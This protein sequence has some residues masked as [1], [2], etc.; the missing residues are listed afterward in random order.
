MEAD[1][2]INWI[3]SRLAYSLKH[4]S[5]DFTSQISSTNN[6][7]LLTSFLIRSSRRAL[8]ISS[9]SS[10]DVSLSFSPAPNTVIISQ[11]YIKYPHIN[12]VQSNHVSESLISADVTLSICIQD[13][14]WLLLNLFI[15]RVLDSDN[16]KVVL[17][18]KNVFDLSRSFRSRIAGDFSL[19]YIIVP[20][21]FLGSI[22][23][24]S[25][26]FEDI[27]S[28]WLTR[29][30]KVIVSP[31]EN[32]LFCSTDSCN[33]SVGEIISL[34]QKVKKYKK[35]HS[36]LKSERFVFVYN[37]LKLSKSWIVKKIDD[38]FNSIQQVLYESEDLL[39]YLLPLEKWVF[40]CLDAAPDSRRDYIQPICRLVYLIWDQCQFYQVQ[41]NF[42]HLLSSIILVIIEVVKEHLPDDLFSVPNRSIV[43]I[44][45]AL[46]L[47]YTFQGCYTDARTRADH[48]LDKIRKENQFEFDSLPE[49]LRAS[50]EFDKI[51]KSLPCKWPAR[52]DHIYQT[53][54]KTVNRLK[55]LLEIAKT[56]Y[57]FEDIRVIIE[58]GNNFSGTFNEYLEDI[59]SKFLSS[60]KPLLKIESNLFDVGD[61]DKFEGIFFAFRNETKTLEYRITNILKTYLSSNCDLLNLKK[62]QLFGRFVNRPI[63]RTSLMDFFVE[64]I[65]N[66]GEHIKD[67]ESFVSNCDKFRGFHHF[68]PTPI[69]KFLYLRALV[70]RLD[71]PY[72]L[73]IRISP[74]LFDLSASAVVSN[75]YLTV[76]SKLEQ[77]LDGFHFIDPELS[78]DFSHLLHKPVLITSGKSHTPIPSLQSNVVH[79]VYVAEYITKLGFPPT[80]I[81]PSLRILLEQYSN[82]E[83]HPQ[84]SKL[85]YT[86]HRFNRIWNN[87]TSPIHRLLPQRINDCKQLVERGLTE[88]TWSCFVLKDF[89]Q[90]LVTA[91]F[92]YL[93]PTLKQTE[94]GVTSIKNA[95]HS[96]CSQSSNLFGST[97][98]TTPRHITEL[99]EKVLTVDLEYES[100]LV[101]SREKIHQILNNLSNSF[102]VNM[103]SPQW[104]QFLQYIDQLLYRGITSQTSKSYSSIQQYLSPLSGGTDNVH[105]SQGLFSINF[106]ITGDSLAF[107]PS[108]YPE[109]Q[110]LSLVEQIKS[111][112]MGVCTR[113]ATIQPFSHP[114][115]AFIESLNNESFFTNLI[116]DFYYVLFVDLN[117]CQDVLQK[118]SQF[119]FL[120]TNDCNTYFRNFISPRTDTSNSTQEKD[121]LLLDSAHSDE[122]AMNTIR[123]NE[124]TFLYPNL[125]SRSKGFPS[126]ANLPLLEDF[127]KEIS[128]YFALKQELLQ[129]PQYLNMGCI[130]VDARGI[131]SFLLS[132]CANWLFTFC[133]YLQDKV[134]LVL[135][136]LNFLFENIEPEV[137]KIGTET[138][139]FSQLMK[140]M[141][142][143][144]KL[145]NKQSDIEHKFSYLQR[146]NRILEKFDFNLRHDIYGF[147]QSTPQKLDHLNAVFGMAKQRIRP[148]IATHKKSIIEKLHTFQLELASISNQFYRSYLFNS[149]CPSKDAR[150][151]LDEYAQKFSDLKERSKDVCEIQSFLE[152]QY[153]NFS[154]LQKLLD[155]FITIRRVWELVEEVTYSTKHLKRDMWKKQIP[156]EVQQKLQELRDKVDKLPQ[157]GS[158]WDITLSI[159]DYLDELKSTV[160][161]LALLQSPSIRE[162]HWKLIL[163]LSPKPRVGSATITDASILM[164]LS[165]GKLI[166]LGLHLCLQQ[167]EAIVE[168]S[169]K[170]VASESIINTF[171][172]VWDGYLLTLEDYTRPIAQSISA[173]ASEQSI[174]A[175][176]SNE[177]LA[178]SS[179]GIARRHSKGLITSSKMSGINSVGLDAPITEPI[180]KLTNI[181]EVF[182]TL[183]EHINELEIVLDSVESIPYQ[184]DLKPWRHKFQ[185]IDTILKLWMEVQNNWMQA[186]KF[187]SWSDVRQN[188]AQEAIGFIVVDK[189]WRLLMKEVQC[190]PHVMRT[191]CKEGRLRVLEEINQSL[192]QTRVAIYKYYDNFKAI[193]PRFYFISSY[194]IHTFISNFN[195]VKVLSKHMCMIFPGVY[196]LALDS[197]Q[198]KNKHVIT[199]V[200]G[201]NGGTVQLNTPIIPDNYDKV[202]T[203]LNDFSANLHDTLKDYFSSSIEKISSER[204]LDQMD[205]NHIAYFLLKELTKAKSSEI[206]LLT[207]RVL[208]STL[209]NRLVNQ[210][211]ISELKSTISGL[212][213]IIILLNRYLHSGDV[214][215]LELMQ[216]DDV[217]LDEGEQ[218][219]LEESRSQH[220]LLTT[221]TYLLIQNLII[222]LFY[223]K[224]LTESLVSL[225]DVT[226]LEN[227]LEW[228]G[229]IKHLIHSDDPT[230]C[231]FSTHNLCVPYVFEFQGD[232]KEIVLFPNTE[233]CFFHLLHS[234]TTNFGGLLVGKQGSGKMSTIKQ[235][236]YLLGRPLFEHSCT[237]HTS[238]DYLKD[239]IHGANNS[240]SLVCFHCI[241]NI[242][243]H[244]MTIFIESIRALFSGQIP[245]RIGFPTQH[246]IPFDTNHGAVLAT[247][248]CTTLTRSPN[249]VFVNVF[250]PHVLI[251]DI[252]VISEVLLYT[253]G[254][255]NARK[256]ALRLNRFYETYSILVDTGTCKSLAYFSVFKLRHLL[257][258]ASDKLANEFVDPV[259]QIR[260]HSHPQESVLES[261]DERIPY[262]R[263][264]SEISNWNCVKYKDE[265]EEI[266][267]QEFEIICSSLVNYLPS[268]T[269][270]L[271]DSQILKLQNVIKSLFYEDYD[272]DKDLTINLTSQHHFSPQNAAL[273]RVMKKMTLEP[274]EYFI[275][276]VGEIWNSLKL[277]HMVLL[278]GP[279]SSGKSTS[280][281][282]CAGIFKDL[283]MS[284][285]LHSIF[286]QALPKENLFGSFNLEEQIWT[287]GLL[288]HFFERAVMSTGKLGNSYHHW[289]HLDGSLDKL[290]CDVLATFNFE[291]YTITS[292]TKQKMVLLPNFRIILESDCAKFLTPSLIAKLGIISF[293][294]IISWR[295]ILHSWIEKQ[296]ENESSEWHSIF[297]RYLPVV[298]TCLF[299]D[300]P[301]SEELTLKKLSTSRRKALQK[302]EFKFAVRLD[303]VC[304]VFSLV[305]LIDSLLHYCPKPSAD[306]K[307]VLFNFAAIWA[308]GGCLDENSR[309]F[310]A[311]I[312]QELF[313]GQ[314]SFPKGSNIWSFVPDF[315]SQS[316]VTP[317]LVPFTCTKESLFLQMPFITDPETKAIIT[318]FD[319]LSTNTI[320]IL[321]SG[322]VGSGKSLLVNHLSKCLDSSDFEQKHTIK[323]K[324]NSRSSSLD[325]W[326]LLRSELVWSSAKCIYVP[327]GNA[328]LHVLVED[329]HLVDVPDQQ[330][331]S[332]TEMLRWIS[333]VNEVFDFNTY[334]RKDIAHVNFI[335]TCNSRLSNL[336]GRLTSHFFL[337]HYQYAT[338]NSQVSI[339]TQLLSCFF[340]YSHPTNQSNSVF[341][342]QTLTQAIVSL[343]AEM[344]ISLKSMFVDTQERSLYLFTLRDISTIFRYLCLILEP[345]CSVKDF[346]QL[347]NHEVY[348]LYEHKLVNYNDTLLFRQLKTRLIHKYFDS[349]VL[350]N[351]LTQPVERYSFIEN[352]LE[353]VSLPNSLLSYYKV[354]SDEDKL[355]NLLNQLSITNI[356]SK[357]LATPFRLD[358]LNR[359]SLLLFS[360]P[361]ISNLI[362]IGESQ[363]VSTLT[364]LASLFNFTLERISQYLASHPDQCTFFKNSGYDLSVFDNYMRD[365]Y[366]RAGINME[367]IIL[368]LDYRELKSKKFFFRLLEFVEDCQISPLF[369]LEQR[370]NI[371]NALRTQISKLSQVFSESLAWNIFLGNLNR[372]LTIVISVDDL[373]INLYQ[374]IHSVP[375]LFNRLKC[376]VC[377]QWD[378][379][380]LTTMCEQA[381][382]QHYP[383][384]IAL[385]PRLN[386]LIAELLSTLFTD[387][388]K[389][390]NYTQSYI[391]GNN[392]FNKFVINFTH[393]FSSLYDKILSQRKIVKCAID[394]L[395]S[396]CKT[397]DNFE[398]EYPNRAFVSEDKKA[399]CSEFIKLIGQ[400]GL[401][402]SQSV[403][404]LQRLEQSVEFLDK[405]HPRMEDA[406]QLA[407]LESKNKIE[408]IVKATH[409][410][411]THDIEWLRANSK[412]PELSHLM[413]VF[414][415]LFKSSTDTQPLTRTIRRLLSNSERFLSQII[416]FHSGNELSEETLTSIYEVISQ[417]ATTVSANKE[418]HEIMEKITN[419]LR[420]IASYYEVILHKVNPLK[421]RIER[422]LESIVKLRNLIDSLKAKITSFNGS[423][424]NLYISLHRSSL[425]LTQ[426]VETYE[427]QSED[428]HKTCSLIQ[429]LGSLPEKWRI[430]S[431]VSDEEVVS[432]ITASA[433]SYGY[434][435]FL[436]SFP[437][438]DQINILQNVWPKSLEKL[439]L[440]INWTEAM[441]LRMDNVI[442]FGV[443][444]A[445]MACKSQ[446]SHDYL[447]TLH[448]ICYFIFYT[449]TKDYLTPLK[450]ISH[451]ISKELVQV[452]YS[453]FISISSSSPYKLTDLTNQSNTTQIDLT[454]SDTHLYDTL[455]DAVFKGHS[456]ILNH[457]DTI[458]DPV[459][460]PLLE[461]APVMKVNK[462][463]K[464]PVQF[465]GRTIRPNMNFKLI[466][467]AN[468]PSFCYPSIFSNNTFHFD[469][470]PSHT[471]C[472]EVCLH[473]LLSSHY[474]Y[475]S[476]TDLF[477]FVVGKELFFQS[478]QRKLT[479]SLAKLFRC[480]VNS[481]DSY[482]PQDTEIS[483]DSYQHSNE[484]VTFLNLCPY[485]QAVREYAENSFQSVTRQ[486]Y[487][488]PDVLANL[489]CSLSCIQEIQVY[490]YLDVNALYPLLESLFT[491][492]GCDQIQPSNLTQKPSL[493]LSDFL[494]GKLDSSVQENLIKEYYTELN[495]PDEVEIDEERLSVLTENIDDVFIKLNKSFVTKSVELYMPY[496]TRHDQFTWLLLSALVASVAGM[497]EDYSSALIYSVIRM[498]SNSPSLQKSSHTKVQKPELIEDSKWDCILRSSLSERCVR[499]LYNSFTDHHTEWNAWICNPMP[500]YKNMPIP[501]SMV[502][503]CPS[504][505]ILSA[506]ALILL[507]I[508]FPVTKEEVFK[509]FI[510][511]HLGSNLLTHRTFPLNQLLNPNDSTLLDTSK[512]NIFYFVMEKEC[513]VAIAK[514]LTLQYELA[515]I[516]TAQGIEIK[517]FS[518]LEL[519]T[520]LPNFEDFSSNQLLLFKDFHLVNKGNRES[521][522]SKLFAMPH[523]PINIVLFGEWRRDIS[524]SLPEVISVFP[525]EN[526]EFRLFPQLSCTEQMYPSMY[527]VF[528]CV[529]ESIPIETK[530]KI[531]SNTYE[532]TFYLVILF[533]CSLMAKRN[534]YQSTLS[535]ISVDLLTTS[536]DNI[537]NL[538]TDT[539][540]TSTCIPQEDE[541]FTILSSIYSLNTETQVQHY[542]IFSEQVLGISHEVITQFIR[543]EQ[544]SSIVPTPSYFSI[545]SDLLSIKLHVPDDITPPLSLPSLPLQIFPEIQFLPFNITNLSVVLE[546]A[547]NTL[548]PIP[549][550][551]NFASDNNSP[552][553]YYVIT[554]ELVEIHG[555]LLTI[556]EKCSSLQHHLNTGVVFIPKPLILIGESLSKRIISREWAEMYNPIGTKDDLCLWLNQLI[557]HF[558]QL[559]RWVASPLEHSSAL[560]LSLFKEIS[561]LLDCLHKESRSCDNVIT[562]LRPLDQVK[563][564][565]KKD[566][567]IYIKGRIN[568]DTNNIF[569][570]DLEHKS[571]TIL[572][573][574]SLPLH[575]YNS[576][577]LEDGKD[578]I[579]NLKLNFNT[580]CFVHCP[581]HA[582][583]DLAS[584]MIS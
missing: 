477:E 336:N 44:E 334:A 506:E 369:S 231:N 206:Y 155:T 537:L 198:V 344:Q 244:K 317:R 36:L 564:P 359:I 39:V 76:R 464:M 555:L 432:I 453:S 320:P 200:I 523:K 569:L 409:M 116:N 472:Y 207:T 444:P 92:T 411:N 169:K 97:S 93:D 158:Q 452:L 492:Y 21:Q 274:D 322:D 558:W 398:V 470:S 180:P 233:R 142:I 316:L 478:L 579:F 139:D 436:S 583:P 533:H 283:G 197:T 224:G 571:Y 524:E 117:N 390:L 501:I 370:G 35:I 446:I 273:L 67:V 565:V 584:S 305:S 520:S 257:V 51:S 159:R 166:D 518:Y 403:T 26:L 461:L 62:M 199:G 208:L 469:F 23:N 264:V 527:H 78:E 72:R 510:S 68:V 160:P 321:I 434:L 96:W 412:E 255:Q 56:I 191:C 553:A 235:F 552:L 450:S 31:R 496:L 460:K 280:L 170:E 17:S 465:A 582:I 49:S 353:H 22:S 417:E 66:L 428:F 463:I 401:N 205:I 38:L 175:H 327:R 519:S 182:E 557:K 102:G 297:D 16:H 319:F 271:P 392:C 95:I 567:I 135:E 6:R 528:E 148:C 7:A 87:R 549:T 140:S 131:R 109:G 351:Y 397:R 580:L 71:A 181:L 312:W 481:G 430:Y 232:H 298:M 237:D 18:L 167:I 55:D 574:I 27:A 32:E 443:T 566:L 261:D 467:S 500:S 253:S 474:L 125:H 581:S 572:S 19:P 106:R 29:I 54:S 250:K 258:I 270:F 90:Q 259:S 356:A 308:I 77:L 81:P 449:N 94:Q 162:S 216:R 137:S 171:K 366:T 114:K 126:R 502:G 324:C 314:N 73:V 415:S 282:V 440:K 388:C 394:I 204:P 490:Y 164:K 173:F 59:L 30:S 410:F 172:E 286:P 157:E 248:Q 201:S 301:D 150:E 292:P 400:L 445:I 291:N 577:Y 345:N 431:Q 234:I 573:L 503:K 252:T 290:H 421:V 281:N 466:F 459:L 99:T 133:D 41:N 236:S 458:E 188:L 215:S 357:W 285:C 289:F 451:S 514:S 406:L 149:D 335:V 408:V 278:L 368:L 516:Y 241:D 165:F 570:N 43:E 396:I 556:R 578:E 5:S 58:N 504:H 447:H 63:I 83:L 311:T 276:R 487:H 186:D 343:T 559:I 260:R 508:F 479:Q 341:T 295:T 374:L 13:I 267:Y 145:R 548:S 376:I 40:L 330:L 14:D 386:G 468:T 293:A 277:H 37:N 383:K 230:A 296:N 119:S 154:S 372:N 531:R 551:L 399:S 136:D 20:R 70:E 576:L 313:Q 189:Q 33:T 50:Y 513:K 103:H 302:T 266:M 219:N 209:L 24:V 108:P 441:N 486:I 304:L 75:Q 530:L 493:V 413:T 429:D 367:R 3:E 217:I 242:Q 547:L 529:Y 64:L 329:I 355:P 522:F 10:G 371:V 427:Q 161:L 111:W 238:V 98:H 349:S 561:L 287:K 509:D 80:L 425:S 110:T 74:T 498:V 554:N 385:K 379:V 323:F 437:I 193:Y 147:Y 422:N 404:S 279:S 47:C 448:S 152:T 395:E 194:F 538:K 331:N 393:S 34:K 251:P 128:V 69:S 560:D 225:C 525:I 42:N 247:A 303:Q 65:D 475:K 315:E 391:P 210:N 212:Q 540:T 517:P 190:D 144:Y 380:Q 350:K 310:F 195:D 526:I 534:C 342:N 123:I 218:E 495:W 505:S 416:D 229:S 333:H 11:Y 269:C 46:L 220:E 52:K 433:I 127:E 12:T 294:S 138:A 387:M 187:F 365:I 86:I 107:H 420:A 332:V 378:R 88:V 228:Q 482:V 202:T 57:D 275:S 328:K 268:L 112:V 156:E 535:N 89:L 455:R 435:C 326:G 414:I 494:K 546:K 480:D 79:L 177:N 488:L 15:P 84:L 82:L 299:R 130:V 423:R 176:S 221:C 442:D 532:Y 361:D 256:I 402:I 183:H 163:K 153:V 375:S 347:W 512:L 104:K 61:D 243:P 203:L 424:D 373:D 249:S 184:E 354:N 545:L 288:T 497:S 507:H 284:A 306:F 542:G 426:Y 419:W 272:E 101:R 118:I 85:F 485:I 227:S 456:L 457:L 185:R 121:Y 543:K 265:A 48:C 113:N 377:P 307:E 568:F 179:T 8:S 363:I 484:L 120:W 473:K 246:Y 382:K 562:S 539:V 499:T 4:F 132:L 245:S 196:E 389:N 115:D 515:S 418:I 53:F 384:H 340:N 211:D 262:P 364:L 483:Q 28:S 439:N 348:W 337:H 25:S 214:D 222:S 151:L 141:R 563:V 521:F 325:L 544:Y 346:I 471:L 454:C 168:K 352:V 438:Q 575:I 550:D 462:V 339:F 362:I 407:I 223:F 100:S 360:P 1:R 129:I 239:F 2:R 105:T 134:I 124:M 358:L 60:L 511:D 122:S 489:A 381:L 318:L 174:S 213:K 226:N 91:V 405:T 536:I 476:W 263:P 146:A 9:S 178:Q 338:F 300:S 143:F 491:E 192:E 240:R 309:I 45:S 254:F 541:I